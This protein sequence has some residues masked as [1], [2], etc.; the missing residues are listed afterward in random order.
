MRD[1]KKLCGGEVTV[2]NMVAEFRVIYKRRP[3]MMEELSGL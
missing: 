3:A 2:K 1:A